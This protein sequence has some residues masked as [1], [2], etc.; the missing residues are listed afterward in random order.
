MYFEELSIEEKVEA[1]LIYFKVKDALRI[2][3]E[4]DADSYIKKNY[5]R[6]ARAK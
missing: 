1:T 4:N 2:K 5:R 6:K 3:G